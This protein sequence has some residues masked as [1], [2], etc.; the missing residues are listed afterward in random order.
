MTM[1]IVGRDV[2]QS[3]ALGTVV[4]PVRN[5]LRELPEV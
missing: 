2:Q 4:G 3:T 5:Q 1:V